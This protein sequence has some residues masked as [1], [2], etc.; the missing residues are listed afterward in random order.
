VKT[1]ESC[2]DVSVYEATGCRLSDADDTQSC[3]GPPS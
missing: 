2:E 1:E 3:Y